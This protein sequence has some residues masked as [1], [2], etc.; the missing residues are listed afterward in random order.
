VLQL[1]T[2]RQLN[3]SLQLAVIKLTKLT[4]SRI[5]RKI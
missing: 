5:H 2:G 1:K 3:I 4:A